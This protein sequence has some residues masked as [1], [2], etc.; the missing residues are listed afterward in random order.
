MRQGSPRR[1]G[2]GVGIRC[3]GAV[4]AAASSDVRALQGVYGTNMTA[5]RAHWRKETG[6]TRVA[7]GTAGPR[8]PALE[9]RLGLG[10]VDL[11]A[12]GPLAGRALAEGRRPLGRRQPPPRL[13]PLSVRQVQRLL[14]GDGEFPSGGLLWYWRGD[15]SFFLKS[16][17]S[18]ELGS[19][20]PGA[21]H[22][23]PPPTA[24]HPR[25]ARGAAQLRAGSLC[26]RGPGPRAWSWHR[27]DPAAG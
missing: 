14:S 3:L 22:R 2:P 9:P 25:G 15:L 12:V 5:G 27:S 16:I 24:A 20:Q 17:T 11:D 7:L 21:P 1:S 8:G 26:A 10:D 23:P 13:L 18:Q 6:V 19:E 4:A